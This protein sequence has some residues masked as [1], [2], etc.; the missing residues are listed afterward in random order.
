MEAFKALLM[1]KDE[2]LI[3]DESS[4]LIKSFYSTSFLSVSSAIRSVIIINIFD[5]F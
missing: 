3:N 4:S 1:F 5:T 2:S